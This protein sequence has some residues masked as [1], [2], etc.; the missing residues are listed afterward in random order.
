MAQTRLLESHR[1]ALRDLARRVVDVPAETKA[2]ESAYQRCVPLVRKAV[3]KV[4]VP[5]DMAV[6][7]K[8]ELA[9]TDRCLNFQLTAGGYE[10]ARTDR[11]LN[12]QL[13]AAGVE[14]FCFREGDG[15]TV[16]SNRGCSSRIYMADDR[17][18][19]A[20]TKWKLAYDAQKNA[21]EKKLEEYINFINSARSF[22]QVLEIWPEAS[23]LAPRI[24]SNLPVAVSED[25]LASIKRDSARRIA[26]RER[27]AE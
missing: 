21:R 16:P 25:T 20:I 24:Q 5:A 6:F 3:E 1:S 4:F 15:M 7:A 19:D 22:E 11:C 12:F 17:T 8:Y 2:E 27:I 13:T 18:T 9:R 10:L 23:E 26:Q 14:Q